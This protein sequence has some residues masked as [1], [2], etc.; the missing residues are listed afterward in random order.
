MLA[1]F[2]MFVTAEAKGSNKGGKMTEKQKQ[3]QKE[4]EAKKADNEKM[5]LAVKAVL[6]VKDKNG[7]GVL[8]KDE[9]LIGEADPAAAAK[10][11]D[12]FNKNGSRDLEKSEIGMSLGL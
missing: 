6:A 7:D 12:E 10:R 2:S 9:Y 4:K 11:F 1:L 5:V 8:S 3:E